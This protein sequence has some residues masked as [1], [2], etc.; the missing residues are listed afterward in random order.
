MSKEPLHPESKASIEDSL[1][2]STRS[3]SSLADPTPSVLM[4]F[5]SRLSCLLITDD[6]LAISLVSLSVLEFFDGLKTFLLPLLQF[7]P[8][9]LLSLHTW[10]GMQTPLNAVADWDIDSYGCIVRECGRERERQARSSKTKQNKT[11]FKCVFSH[12]V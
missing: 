12:T 8:T 6:S 1:V 7:L 9:F 10:G 11:P 5:S 2:S 3:L 4:L